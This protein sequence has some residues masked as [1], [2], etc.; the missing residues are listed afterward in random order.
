MLS[1]VKLFSDVVS[2]G[3]KGSIALATMRQGSM[4]DTDFQSRIKTYQKV[5]SDFSEAKSRTK[6][7]SDYAQTDIQANTYFD[8]SLIGQSN[9]WAGYLAI[10]RDMN[11]PHAFLWYLNMLEKASNTTVLPNVGP[12][13]IGE[14][15]RA[16]V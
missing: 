1:E 6:L 11:A 14:I 5:F 4:S 15:G 16:H 9:S 2:Q 13:N 8:A 3:T 12:E 10:E 7:S